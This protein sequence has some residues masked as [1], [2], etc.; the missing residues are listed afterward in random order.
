M[1]GTVTAQING[2]KLE[3]LQGNIVHQDVDA[4]VNAAN[5]SLLGGGGVDGAIHRAAGPGLLA[6]TRTLGGCKVGEAKITGGYNLPAKHIIHTVGPVYDPQYNPDGPR[7]LA[8]A[9]RR[10]MELAAEHG[11]QSVAFPAISTGAYRYPAVEAAEISLKTVYA[12]LTEQETDL[13]L[14]RFV[15]YSGDM[16]AVYET[17]LKKLA[18]Q[19]PALSLA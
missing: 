16:F 11:L 7:L 8:D 12:F 10:S 14:V 18:G 1:T 4:V 19:L 2:I 17:T 5:T 15:L 3:L 6:E 13:S 9:Y